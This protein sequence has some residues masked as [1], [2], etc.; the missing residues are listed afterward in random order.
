LEYVAQLKIY[1]LLDISNMAEDWWVMQR[2]ASQFNLP[3]KTE[4]QL[5]DSDLPLAA[6]RARR[7][8]K[9][10][11]YHLSE[12][13]EDELEGSLNN[14]NQRGQSIQKNPPVFP[15][16]ADNTICG[17]DVLP[18]M[19]MLPNMAPHMY[20]HGYQQLPDYYSMTCDPFAAG[21]ARTRG[22]LPLLHDQLGMQMA[23]A[24]GMPAWQLPLDTNFGRHTQGQRLGNGGAVLDS[25]LMMQNNPFYSTL[26]AGGQHNG[27]LDS[28]LRIAPLGPLVQQ[29]ASQNVRR[30]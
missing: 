19:A 1:H 8:T 16:T 10:R 22:P 5:E 6:R 7:S 25:N 4:P 9:Q 21:I 11:R 28:P 15:V 2:L 3:Q 27:R 13:D 14:A 17:H 26:H 24:Q 20:L 29:P 23:T 30:P 18:N 12:T